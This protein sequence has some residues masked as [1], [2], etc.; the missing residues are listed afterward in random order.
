[1]RTYWERKKSQINWRSEETGWFSNLITF[2]NVSVAP[3]VEAF[4]PGECGEGGSEDIEFIAILST[5]NY[6]LLWFL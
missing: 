3:A 4:P 5:C 6:W 1:M 2:P